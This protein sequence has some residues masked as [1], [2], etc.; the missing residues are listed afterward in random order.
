MALTVTGSH[1]VPIL[2]L[3]GTNVACVGVSTIHEFGSDPWLIST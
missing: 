2:N 1:M 3:I